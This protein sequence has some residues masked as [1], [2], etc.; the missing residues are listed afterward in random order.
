MRTVT[1][2]DLGS[3]HV[4]KRKFEDS[5]FC[6]DFGEC[7]GQNPCEESNAE[8]QSSLA[9]QP[10]ATLDM[11]K[12]RGDEGEKRDKKKRRKKKKKK[13]KMQ[14]GEEEDATRR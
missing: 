14:E 9:V 12:M 1:V 8:Y 6:V 5:T 11:Q 3:L 2:T 7:L 4:S 13:K 10:Y